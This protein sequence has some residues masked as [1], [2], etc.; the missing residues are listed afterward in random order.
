MHH[1]A[2]VHEQRVIALREQVSPVGDQERRPAFDEPAHGEHDLGL[3]S[4]VDG[5]RR[6]VED[7]DRGVLEKGPCDRESLAL[8][9]RQLERSAVKMLR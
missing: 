6:L 2:S 3:G 9:P 4:G 5:A 1:A 7:H 8:P